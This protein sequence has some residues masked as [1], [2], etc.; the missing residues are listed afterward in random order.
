MPLLTASKLVHAVLVP[1]LYA[2]IKIT[3]VA[4]LYQFLDRAPLD[5]I[6]FMRNVTLQ[7]IDSFQ[8]QRQSYE[9]INEPVNTFV[10]RLLMLQLR[11]INGHDTNHLDFSYAFL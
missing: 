9:R 11:P 2:D 4:N 10:C 7:F 5:N 3:R 8:D 6:V 1:L